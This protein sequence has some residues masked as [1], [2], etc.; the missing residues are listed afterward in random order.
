MAYAVRTNV[1]AAKTRL[2]V[3]KLLQ[4]AG[5]TRMAVYTEAT[6]ADVLFEVHDRRLRFTIRLDSGTT[7]KSAQARRAQGPS[8]DSCH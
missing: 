3:E 4:K 7:E 8:P 6:R 5:A 1:D 2:E